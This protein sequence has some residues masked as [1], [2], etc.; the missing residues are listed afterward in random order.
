MIL[1]DRMTYTE[2]KEKKTCFHLP[3]KK[4]QFKSHQGMHIAITPRI[5]SHN[6]LY[7]QLSSGRGIRSLPF[8]CFDLIYSNIDLIYSRRPIRLAI[9]LHSSLTLQPSEIFWWIYI[10]T[11]SLAASLLRWNGG[12]PC[13]PIVLNSD[14]RSNDIGESSPTPPRQPSRGAS[15]PSRKSY[16]LLNID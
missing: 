15:S 10:S 12:S 1:K 5:P 3:S 11:L 7:Q 6:R 16:C 9:D 14:L 13:P 8:R 2:A 4:N